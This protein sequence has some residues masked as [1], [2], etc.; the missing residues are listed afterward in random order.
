MASGRKGRMT[1]KKKSS[2]KQK[3]KNRVKPS[4][5]R[6]KD[7]S[8][9]WQEN[10]GKIPN[11]ILREEDVVNDVV[12]MGDEVGDSDM[13]MIAEQEN[14]LLEEEPIDLKNPEVAAELSE[15]P[16]RLYLRQIGEVKLLDSDRE[17]RLATLIEAN[18]FVLTLRRRPLAK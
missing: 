18:R 12:M 2:Q 1:L 10:G 9:A 3:H 11:G 17:F 7:P 15:D 4:Q 14:E 16:V 8:E 5:P 13:S 6:A